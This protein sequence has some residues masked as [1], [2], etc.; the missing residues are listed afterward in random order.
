MPDS[1][2]VDSGT[3]ISYSFGVAPSYDDLVALLDNT[4]VSPTGSFV[5]TT[6]H[7]LVV[8]A[9]SV[10]ALQPQDSSLLHSARAIISSG[11]PYEAY[12]AYEQNLSTLRTQLGDSAARDMQRKALAKGF[13]PVGDAPSL[14]NATRV[15]AESLGRRSTGSQAATRKVRVQSATLPPNGVA[16]VYVNGINTAL[17]AFDYEVNEISGLVWDAGYSD[18]NQYLLDYYWNP[19]VLK[20][21]SQSISQ[22]TCF[23]QQSNDLQLGQYSSLTTA[24]APAADL[25]QALLEVAAAA[26]DL[27]PGPADP[28]VL[29]FAQLIEGYLASG[30]RVVIIGH[31]QGNLYAQQALKSISESP[32]ASRLGCVGVV[33]IAPPTTLGWPVGG[34][35]YDGLI[36]QGA[37]THDLMLDIDALSPL[38]LPNQARRLYTSVTAFWDLEVGLD[39]LIPLLNLLA[40]PSKYYA[41]LNIH[42]LNSYLADP[43]DIEATIVEAE[44]QTRTNCPAAQSMGPNGSTSWTVPAGSSVTPSVI[45]TD[46][47]GHPVGG[48]SVNWTVA[49]GGG[50]ISSSTTT[51][52]GLG[53]AS[54]T[55][56]LG[57]IAGNNT[58]AASSTGLAGS[59][60]SFTGVGTAGSPT[61]LRFSSPPPGTGSSGVPLSPPVATQLTDAVGNYVAQA[62]VVVSASIDSQ[63]SNAGASLTPTSATSATTNASGIATFNGLAITGPVG[64]YSLAFSSSGLS[65]AI[66]SPIVLSTATLTPC[67]PTSYPPTPVHTL[68][69]PAPCVIVKD[70]SGY[71]VSGV[72]VTFAVTVGGGSVAPLSVTT[73]ASGTATTTW[74]L[75]TTAGNNTLMAT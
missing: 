55:W 45:I 67:S 4:T 46:A 56:T 73:G 43:T 41:D 44:G 31:S 5:A 59:P 10:I 12:L 51:T 68:A 1:L 72:T 21:S 54:V 74:L 70:G 75:G 42:Y 39:A 19:D 66:S 37:L 52:N 34:S 71:P 8:A 49:S 13:D 9:D 3:V 29:G 14:A 35:S 15:I 50:S 2:E 38:L 32:L 11:N 48:V 65:P 25:S 17:D 26:F 64:T 63:P 30:S 40:I 69:G 28:D 33:G 18:P 47:S 16:F 58:L 36:A 23:E 20:L 61:Q 6:S 57:Y 22:L 27:P 7:V 60:V 53:I 62:G 24:C